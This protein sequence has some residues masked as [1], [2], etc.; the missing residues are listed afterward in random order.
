MTIGA[1]RGYGCARDVFVSLKPTGDSL[2]VGGCA[3]DGRR[4]VRVISGGAGRVLWYHL[5]CCLFPEHAEKVTAMVPTAPL[6]PAD[7]PAITSHVAVARNQHNIVEITGWGG[8]EEWL[9]C[10]AEDEAQRLWRS[11]DLLLHPVGWQG[12]HSVGH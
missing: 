8:Q 3:E 5:T 9:L 2:V 6:R 4:F 1:M 11:L 12:R 7:Q 10:L